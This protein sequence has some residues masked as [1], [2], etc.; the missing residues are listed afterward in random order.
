MA[1]FNSP[2]ST[3]NVGIRGNPQSVKPIGREA[4][5]IAASTSMPNFVGAFS[6]LAATPTA[7]GQIGSQALT[8]VSNYTMDRLGYKLGTNP[9][10]DVLPP[11][12]E[13]DKHFVQSYSNQA[14]ATLSLQGEKLMSAGQLE[15]AK[16]NR[17]SPSLINS[18]T[19]NMAKG[20]ENL[21]N[22]APST[23]RPQL[24][25]QL[26][27]NLVRSTTNLQSKLITQQKQDYKDQM[28]ALNA[29]TNKD[30]Y[31]NA[32]SGNSKEAQVGLDTQIARNK[33]LREQGII[34]RVQEE[35]SNQTARQTFFTGV[36]SQQAIAAKDAGKLEA[37]L[38]NLAENKPKDISYLEW[39]TVT[40]NVLGN[41]GQ[42]ESLEKRDQ[43]LIESQ[44]S[45]AIL[46]NKVTDDVL[47]EVKEKLSPQNYTQAMINYYKSVNGRNKNQQQVN[48]LIL[49][50]GSAIA[51]AAYTS[52]TVNDAFT[53][54]SSGYNQKLRN[55]GKP[56]VSEIE[57]K[58]AVM[59]SSGAPVQRFTTEISNMITSGNPALMEQASNAY[60]VL[61]Y[62][63]VPL[64]A[65]N[66]RLLSSYNSQIEQGRT[67]L[68]AAQIA[69]YNNAP[70]NED[71]RKAIEFQWSN[72]VKDHKLTDFN[73]A[74]SHARDL[75]DIPWF[76]DVPD[77]ASIVQK[78]NSDFESNYKLMGGDYNGARNLTV[79]NKKL[80]Y[81]LTFVNGKKQFSYMPIEK[82]MGVEDDSA[83]GI[84]Q[85]NIAPQLSKQLEGTKKAFDEG[86]NDYYYRIEPRPSYDEAIAAKQE[87]D[88][89]MSV[90]DYGVHYWERQEQ[91]KMLNQTVSDYTASKPL[92]IEKV[93]RSAPGHK[94][95][96]EK[97]QIS[98]RANDSL[99]LG[100]DPNQPIAGAYDIVLR[101]ENGR[102][103]PIIGVDNLF[104][105][106]AV[107]RP[108]LNKLQQEYFTLSGSH[109]IQGDIAKAK[110]E[111][112]EK[113]KG[114]A[115]RLED[116]DFKQPFLF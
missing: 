27:T 58:I 111:F 55:S 64:S 17:L 102:E 101:T 94:E 96:I 88:K 78:T 71:R 15:L 47:S 110:K 114:I 45:L 31:E 63:K 89:I 98:L 46:E 7:I 36:Y 33:Q 62:L 16:A 75:L 97:Y 84:I 115:R 93:W 32:M 53:Y 30:I 57:A 24:E 61:G 25:N 12:T 107:F 72:Y 60:Q 26:Q 5:Q 66:Q 108:D 92:N 29:Q 52:K 48:N 37:Y 76:T 51:H 9:S 43:S 99:G 3:P 80:T 109:D 41:I 56:E 21:L 90:R 70:Q 86:P 13:A 22:N 34:S 81:G 10:G 69:V 1:D 2:E 40:R 38:S 85:N 100:L 39:S 59:L 91:L 6:S 73:K 54:L 23:I 68:E 20:F 65:A 105:G 104:N 11:I 95:H 83:A 112:T 113:R 116:N 19:G 4:T 44:F 87:I 82:F 106:N 49:E 77:L 18:Y 103:M 8:A 42:I 74:E 35:Q 28:T 50:W 67:P 79:Q 14:Y